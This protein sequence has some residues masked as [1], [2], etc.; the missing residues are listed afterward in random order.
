MLVPAADS[1]VDRLHGAG[2]GERP[3][4][5]AVYVDPLAEGLPVGPALEPMEDGARSTAVPGLPECPLA[6]E[7]VGVCAGQRSGIRGGKLPSDGERLGARDMVVVDHD[8]RHR[9]RVE[10]DDH[11]LETVGARLEAAADPR[12]VERDGLRG[13]HHGLVRPAVFPRAK[14]FR[15]AVR[16]PL[17]VV[18]RAQVLVVLVPEAHGVEG[19]EV[20]EVLRHV[21]AGGEE[22]VEALGLGEGPGVGGN[23]ERGA[24]ARE[25]QVPHR[26]E[27]GHAEQLRGPA[28]HVGHA[29][30]PAAR[31]ARVPRRAVHGNPVREAPVARAPHEVPV[32]VP[33]AQV[34][35]ARAQAAPRG[36]KGVRER[37][38]GSG[39]RSLGLQVPPH[40]V[41]AAPAARAEH[42]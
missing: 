8:K 1:Q 14:D 40:V 7:P 10:L 41:G 34:L 19:E 17:D 13:G 24:V 38:R 30:G 36:H 18:H 4:V 26:V 23:V 42:V 21:A 31:G 33:R 29:P 5:L 12:G 20:G 35:H 11:L 22:R 15:A 32:A 27:G 37:V 3:A 16:G 39:L 6:A 28:H 9:R 25:E 2:R